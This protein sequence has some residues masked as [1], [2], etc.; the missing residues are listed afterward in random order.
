LRVVLS[1][2]NWFYPI[3]QMLIANNVLLIVIHLLRNIAAIEIL[4]EGDFCYGVFTVQ[5]LGAML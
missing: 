3:Q 5:R 4:V 1:K 2:N